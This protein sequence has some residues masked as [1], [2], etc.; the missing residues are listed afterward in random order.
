MS[1]GYR[2]V[3][4]V[5]AQGR[6]QAG[7]LAGERVI[8]ATDILGPKYSSVIEILRD[9]S[10]THPAIAK[11]VEGG[12]NAGTPLSSVKL[13]AP[14]LY[15]GAFFCAGANYWDHLNEMAEIAKKTTG[16]D[17]HITKPAEPWFFLKT[18]AGSIIG[19][20]AGAPAEFLQAGRL[21]SR[22]RR[23]HRQEDAQY[24]GEGRA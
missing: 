16:R 15:P 6:P 9:W 17:V 23:D 24:L 1:A 5:G 10:E 12:A 2:L 13:L 7:V 14:V 11:A 20:G 18:A 19:D 8:A 22:D 21:G 4:Y 3:S